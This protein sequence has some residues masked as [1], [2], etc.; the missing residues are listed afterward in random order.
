MAKKKLEMELLD[1]DILF[2]NSPVGPISKL[3]SHNHFEIE[4]VVMGKGHQTFDDVYFDLEVGDVFLC[5]PRDVHYIVRDTADFEFKHLKIKEDALPNWLLE[6]CYLLKNPVVFR[7]EGEDYRSFC[8]LMDVGIRECEN[9]RPLSGH[10]KAELARV[11]MSMFLRLDPLTQNERTGRISSK[12]MHYIQTGNRFAGRVTLNELATYVGYSSYHTSVVFRKETGITI[13]DY[14][15]SV[16]IDNAKAL[17]LETKNTISSIMKECG[18]SSV[19]NFYAQFKK[20]VGC[21]PV[22]FR[23]RL[24][25]SQN[26]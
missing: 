13:Q 6:R 9:P 5:R 19:S 3:H 21:T 20:R 1:Q 14:L 23:T 16:R 15:T 18:F 2:E 10:V 24:K 26:I 22:E 12:I 25:T 4:V 7:L 8:A 17:L 11:I